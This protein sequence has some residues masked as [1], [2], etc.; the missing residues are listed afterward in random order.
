MNFLI[1]F[2]IGRALV[3]VTAAIFRIIFAV[4][5]AVAMLIWAILR[6]LYRGCR[7]I[8]GLPCFHKE[9]AVTMNVLCSV[10]R[11]EPH[12]AASG[13]CR[14]GTHCSCADNEP[15]IGDGESPYGSSSRHHDD[16]PYG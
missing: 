4:V 12:V 1:G 9:G 16:S 2:L 5:R 13:Q 15:Y 8:A 7:H 10:A 6:L 3:N 11:G 14:D